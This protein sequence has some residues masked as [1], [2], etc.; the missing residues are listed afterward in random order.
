MVAQSGEN[1]EQLI[2]DVLMITV[3]SSVARKALGT[4][5]LRAY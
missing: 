2:V 1:G 4:K 3:M 5:L